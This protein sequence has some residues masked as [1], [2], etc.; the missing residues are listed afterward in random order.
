MDW[1]EARMPSSGMSL[2]VGTT[3]VDIWLFTLKLIS[4]SLKWRT[5]HF[6]TCD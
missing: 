6:S 4:I 3:D 1:E 2:A 5:T